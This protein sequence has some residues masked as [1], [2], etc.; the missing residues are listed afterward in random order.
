MSLVAIV[1]VL[2]IILSGHPYQYYL[3]IVISVLAF[4]F[5]LKVIHRGVM[6]RG[7]VYIFF[8]ILHICILLVSSLLTNSIPLTVN[9]WGVYALAFLTFW[10]FYS[11][12]I[13]KN[14][15]M[16]YLTGTLLALVGAT[17]CSLII[18]FSTFASDSVYPL[19]MI[20][21][22]YGHSHL[23]AL[24]VLFYPVS[25]YFAFK[26]LNHTLIWKTLHLFLTLGLL[27]S[28]ARVAISVAFIQMLVFLIIEGKKCRSMLLLMILGL[29]S[30]CIF[31]LVI[32]SF[33][34]C[35][36]VDLDNHKYIVVTKM[37]QKAIKE[38]P[39]RYYWT[40]GMLAVANSPWVGFGPGT[41]E[42]I[43]SKYAQTPSLKT[44]YAHNEYLT[45]FA[46]A[47][48]LAGISYIALLSLPVIAY[49]KR[50]HIRMTVL[51]DEYIYLLIGFVSFLVLLFFDY[52]LQF[53]PSVIVFFSIFGILA[54][55]Q[56]MSMIYLQKDVVRSIIKP[57]FYALII[58]M[59]VLLAI[60]LAIF[61]CTRAN[62]HSLI[63]SMALFEPNYV[64]NILK[65]NNF[66]PNNKLVEILY[67]SH[68]F[69]V[70]RMA[71]DRQKFVDPWT[72]VNDL[73]YSQKYNPISL[74]NLIFAEKIFNKSRKIYS[75]NDYLMEKEL[76]IIAHKIAIAKLKD[77]LPNDAKDYYF[78]AMELQPWNANEFRLPINEQNPSKEDCQFLKK[79]SSFPVEP[80]GDSREQAAVGYINCTKSMN[81]SMSEMDKREFSL[82]A[83][84]MADWARDYLPKEYSSKLD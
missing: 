49:M 48:V 20:Y 13:S 35:K 24:I 66:E 54:S 22:K 69:W 68:P 9:R 1:L 31:T 21:P 7:E 39:R 14:G 18:S 53:I 78:V 15:F 81:V 79:I 55:R 52:S 83:I 72:F 82:R 25:F 74:D 19:N 34:G 62:N 65:N 10:T 16:V 5:I 6:K 60:W 77:N 4:P 36:Y 80:F 28:S 70:N 33:V 73:T 46:E 59:S 23:S 63:K 75:K 44:L 38:E 26:Q 11:M 51:N 61:L 40:Q 42:L 8:W 67:S 45:V 30:F 12:R 50:I 3:L 2:L 84:Q 57:I 56:S 43:S 29:L 71:N 76:S 17:L 64:S 37:C 32:F 47:G 58:L 41:F 27:I